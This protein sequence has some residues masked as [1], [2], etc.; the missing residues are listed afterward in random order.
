MSDCERLHEGLVAQPVDTA[1]SLAYVVAGIWVWRRHRWLGAALAG[2]GAGSVAYHAVD[3][4]AARVL[5]DGSIVVLAAVV[6]R[7]LPRAVRAARAAPVLAATAVGSM[8]AAV[9]LQALGRTGGPLCDPDAV[10][11]AHAGW[12]VLTA[13]AI[14]CAGGLAAGARDVRQTTRTFCASSPLRPGAVSNSTR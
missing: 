14:A 2:V 7:I 1:S 4:A 10:L 9:P 5:H 6:G 3:G 13:I 11:Q 12:H 8:A